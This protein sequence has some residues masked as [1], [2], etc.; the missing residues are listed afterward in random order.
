MDHGHGSNLHHVT[1]FHPLGKHTVKRQCS[2]LLGI[3]P[4]YSVAQ[5]SSNNDQSKESLVITPGD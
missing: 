2:P 1:T 5:T 4:F 3:V